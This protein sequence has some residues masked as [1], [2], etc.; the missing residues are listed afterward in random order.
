[1]GIIEYSKSIGQN[2][3]F[4]G[5]KR[6]GMNLNFERINTDFKTLDLK[7][8]PNNQNPSEKMKFTIDLKNNGLNLHFEII[9]T[10]FKPSEMEF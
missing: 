3:V 1:M 7:T 8:E 2:A 4:Y 10:D 5:F 6:T 9:K